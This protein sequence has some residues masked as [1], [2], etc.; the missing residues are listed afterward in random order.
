MPALTS[1]LRYANTPLNFVDGSLTITKL[2][3]RNIEKRNQLQQKPVMIS[4]KHYILNQ[5]EQD[6]TSLWK[7][8]MDMFS[9]VESEKHDEES[10]VLDEDCLDHLGDSQRDLVIDFVP[11]QRNEGS[12]SATKK[13]SFSETLDFNEQED[14]YAPLCKD[15]ARE[16]ELLEEALRLVQEDD[17]EWEPLPF[18]QASILEVTSVVPEE[19]HPNRFYSQPPPSNS[20]PLATDNKTKNSRSATNDDLP[21]LLDAPSNLMPSKHKFWWEEEEQPPSSSSSSSP[22]PP[23]DPSVFARFEQTMRKSAQSQL[24]LQD[25]D[26]RNGLP[27]SHCTTMVKTAR[28]RTQLLKGIVLPKWNGDP[29]IPGAQVSKKKRRRCNPSTKVDDVNANKGRR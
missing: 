11:Q 23:L 16:H 18:R 5:P 29:L 14:L 22:L 6:E 21:A 4:D 13:R 12:V 10:L 20:S 24:A 25:W 15:T 8:T 28:S 27:R 7:S 3:K 2:T 1:L 17:D 26:E 19:S 9:V